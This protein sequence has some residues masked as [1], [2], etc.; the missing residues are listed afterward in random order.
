MLKD[1]YS[2]HSKFVE[3]RFGVLDVRGFATLRQ[4]QKKYSESKRNDRVVYNISF[5]D[6]SILLDP[7]LNTA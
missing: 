5:V 1:A 6:W 2:V 4:K 3:G 7:T